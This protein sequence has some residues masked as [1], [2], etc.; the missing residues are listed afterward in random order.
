RR[1]PVERRRLKRDPPLEQ[2][3]QG[4][5]VK[6]VGPALYARERRQLWAAVDIGG[7][8]LPVAEDQARV[9]AG[10]L[11]LEVAGQP[12]LRD[13]SEQPRRLGDRQRPCLLGLISELAG[14]IGQALHRPEATGTPQGDGLGVASVNL[15]GV[16]AQEDDLRLVAIILELEAP[17]EAQGL[18]RRV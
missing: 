16:P 17:S 15:D 4:D 11:D 18:A 6:S 10:A 13:P 3:A 8:E 1:W 12:I 7:L 9:L 14:Q 5:A 2:R